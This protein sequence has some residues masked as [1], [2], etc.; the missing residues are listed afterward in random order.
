[1]S[2]PVSGVS[3]WGRDPAV[4]M[5][6]IVAVTI[7]V[8]HLLPFSVTLTG[9]LDAVWIAAGAVV[10]ALVA[11]AEGQ[12]AAILGLVR[13]GL[14]LGVVLNWHIAEAQQALI[15]AAA[16]ALFALVLRTQMSAPQAADGVWRNKITA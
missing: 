3:W 11:H 7:A 12:L 16:E 13:A 1:M 6:A 5:A 9:A 8:T 14:A 4:V 2:S 10:V 15:L